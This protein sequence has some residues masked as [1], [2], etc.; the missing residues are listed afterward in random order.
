MKISQEFDEANQNK[1]K[2]IHRA[3]KETLKECIQESREQYPETLKVKDIAEI[4]RLHEQS[5]YELLNQGQLPGAKKIM[6]WRV[7]R[8]PFLLWWFGGEN[9]GL[10]Q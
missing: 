4:T 9:N 2:A 1:R 6:G 8:D 10:G 3:I 7:P 5:V